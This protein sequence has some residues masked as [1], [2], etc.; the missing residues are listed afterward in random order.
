MVSTHRA[1]T[2]FRVL[3]LPQVD[4]IKNLVINTGFVL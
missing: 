3:N 4:E 2:Q 1:V